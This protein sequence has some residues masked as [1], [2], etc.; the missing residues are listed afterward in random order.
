[1]TISKMIN[2]LPSAFL[3]QTPKIILAKR[4]NPNLTC[5]VQDRMNIIQIANLL[6]PI[7]RVAACSKHPPS[8]LRPG[9]MRLGRVSAYL[10][11]LAWS[12]RPYG[13]V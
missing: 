12:D 13:R 10:A 4:V 11:K 2:P 5:K 9:V 8:P 1:M 7:A 3:K 6:D